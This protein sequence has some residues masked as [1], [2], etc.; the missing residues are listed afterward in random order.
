MAF[1]EEYVSGIEAACEHYDVPNIVL[2][3]IEYVDEAGYRQRP[4]KKGMA[5][6]YTQIKDFIEQ[7]GGF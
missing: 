7:N 2:E 5:D 6:A 1:P 4:T 3:N